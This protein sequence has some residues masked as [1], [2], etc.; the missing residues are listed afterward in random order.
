MG[1]SNKPDAPLPVALGIAREENFYD[2]S[3]AYRILCDCGDKSHDVKMFIDVETTDVFGYT[4]ISFYVETESPWWRTKYSRIKAAWEIL[5]S[6]RIKTESELLLKS[7]TVE[8]LIGVLNQ[9]RKPQE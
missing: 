7:E 2:G 1:Q 6:G 3:S 8:T 4:S 9:T 5:K